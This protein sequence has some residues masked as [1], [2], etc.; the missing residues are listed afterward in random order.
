M[1]EVDHWL[2]IYASG[3]CTS[4]RILEK[5]WLSLGVNLGYFQDLK[6]TRANKYSPKGCAYVAVLSKKENFLITLMALVQQQDGKPQKKPK[7]RFF[8]QIST[9]T[10]FC[11]YASAKQVLRLFGSSLDKNR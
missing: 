3:V 4:G 6:K 8:I 2:H 5:Q 10:L 9:L 7:D 11:F 1:G